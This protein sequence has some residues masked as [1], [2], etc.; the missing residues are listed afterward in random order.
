MSS[1]EQNTFIFRKLI[2]TDQIELHNVPL[3]I[4]SKRNPHSFPE[5]PAAAA[6]RPE[7]FLKSGSISYLIFSPSINTSFLHNC[8]QRRK[9]S[10]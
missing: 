2:Q 10:L 7:A 5:A 3:K 4:Q 9:I 8:S 6:N 1:A